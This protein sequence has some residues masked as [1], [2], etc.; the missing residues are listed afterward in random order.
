MMKLSEITFTDQW[1]IINKPY[2]SVQDIRKITKLGLPRITK[3]MPEFEKWIKQIKKIDLS[4]INPY[5]RI[6]Y[7][8][9]LVIEFF[10]INTKTIEKAYLI[11]NKKS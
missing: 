7:P 6:V 4:K 9:I 1:K 8:T 11:E 5:S 3:I 10:E 2:C